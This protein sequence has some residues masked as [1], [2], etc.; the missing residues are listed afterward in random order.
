MFVDNI[1]AKQ[2][3]ER[4]M[5]LDFREK[6]TVKRTIK[7]FTLLVVFI[8]TISFIPGA[9]LS[10]N[11]NATTGAH[12]LKGYFIESYDGKAKFYDG[13]NYYGN[14]TTVELQDPDN[15]AINDCMGAYWN[16]QNDYGDFSWDADYNPGGWS[17]G[18][19]DLGNEIYFINEVPASEI[20]GNTSYVWS[21]I[22]EVNGDYVA[23]PR[24]SMIGQYEPIPKPELENN[25]TDWIKI[26]VES[27]DYTDWDEEKGVS[28]GNGTYEEFVSYSVFIKGGGYNGWTFVG[29]TNHVSESDYDGQYDDPIKPWNESIDPKT[30]TT[31]FNT[32]NAT[33]L[34]PGKQYEFKVR[35]NIGDGLF[36]GYN[37]G[38]D[39]AYT[40]WGSGD[41]MNINT[42][43][44]H[45]LNLNA[46]NGG[47][48]QPSP[49]THIYTK[50]TEVTIEA[51]PDQGYFFERW[52]GDY[53]TGCQKEKS[54]NVIMDENKSLTAD[55]TEKAF[56]NV[57]I[58]GYDKEI[59]EG[60]DIQINYTVK[61]TGGVEDTQDIK[62]EVYSKE[63]GNPITGSFKTDPDVTIGPD[64]TQSGI[65]NW[66]TGDSSAGDYYFKIWSGNDTEN[67]NFA[68]LDK[69][70]LIVEAPT[71]KGNISVDG[72]YITSY[73][74]QQSFLEGELVDLE[75]FAD[76]GYNFDEWSGDNSTIGDNTSNKTTIEMFDNYTIQAQFD[77]NTYT[78]NISSKI[79]G[80]VTI[81]GRGQYQFNHGEIVDLECKAE[82][83]YHFV[84]WSGDNG[85]IMNTSDNSTSIEILD[86][87]SIT[88]EF[89]INT[90][91]LEIS[92]SSG[93]S[94]NRPGEGIFHYNHGKIIDLEAVSKK[95]YHF[96]E[97]SGDNAT[98]DDTSA[99]Q[100]TIKMLNDYSI[101]AVFNISSYTLNITSENGGAVNTPGEGSFDYEYGSIIELEALADYG[102]HFVRWSGDNISI[103]NITSNK[104]SIKILSDYSITAEFSINT[105]TL[106]ISSSSGGYVHLPGEGT[107][108][109]E[110]G[111]IV[112][113]EAVSSEGYHF[114]E[115]TGDNSTISNTKDNSTSIEMLDDHTITAMFN[116]NS[117]TLTIS[118]SQGGNVVKPGEGTH[119]YDHGSI[120]D[121]EGLANEGYHFVRWAGD[122]ETITDTTS[123]K[124]TIEMLD[125]YSINAGFSINTYTLNIS[126]TKG[127]D[128]TLP[129]EGTYQ[130]SHGTA[131][132]IE[133]IADQGRSF[134]EWTGDN[135]TVADT[136]SNLTTIE[137]LNDYTIIAEFN[138][139]TYELTI[140][141]TTGGTVIK[142]GETT[143]TFDHGKIVNIE[144]NADQGYNFVEWTGDN[145]T[146]ADTTDNST[147][148]DMLDNYTITAKFSVN[149]YSLEISSSTGG[150]VTLPGEGTHQYEH[151]T[152]VN[153]K[154]IPENGYHFVRW[155]GDNNSIKNTKDNS[156]TIE[157][158]DD[159]TITALFNVNSYTLT[160]SSTSGGNVVKP[161][162]GTHQYEHGTIVDLEAI[163]QKGYHFNLWGGDNGTITED[164]SNKT[165]IEMFDDYSIIAKFDI[166]TYTLDI[167]STE[168]GNVIEP[169][170][171][172]YQYEHGTTI[173]LEVVSS[174][175]YHFVRW[176][177]DN[178]SISDTVA[179]STTIEMLND[180]SIT[181]EFRINT[182]TLDISSTKGGNVAEPGEGT[183]QY[184]HGTS[185]DIE[186]I[187]DQGRSFVEWTG[188][189]NTVA[190]T[191]SNLTTIEML[192]DYTIIAEF[193]VRTYELTIDST[194]GGTVIQPEETTYSFNHGKTVNIEALAY[195]G[196]HFVEW[197]G[198]N[199]TIANTKRNQTTIE[200]LDD[201]SITAKFDINTYSLNIISS[202]NGSVVDPGEGEYRYEHGTKVDIEAVSDNGYH[203]N[204]WSG[205][206]QTIANKNSNK[207][208]IELLSECTITAEFGINTYTL[209]ISSSKGG[210]VTLPGEG[211]YNYEY[212][213]VVDLK[214]VAD[215]DYIFNRWTGDVSQ[216]ENTQKN[217]TTINIKNN[218]S[219]A[220]NFLKVPTFEIQGLD[221]SPVE[222]YYEYDTLTIEVDIHNHGDLEGNH[223]IKIEI[224]N[225]TIGNE[226]V[227]VPPRDDV[228]VEID[229]TPVKKDLGSK[230]ITVDDQHDHALS[231][232]VRIFEHPKVLTK[233]IDEDINS[234]NL[235]GNL[236]QIGLED[237]I[238]AYF[239]YREK[240]NSNWK[241]SQ[242][243]TISKENSYNIQV[244][245]L[246]SNT[247]YEYKAIIKWDSRK[248]TGKNEIFKT[249]KKPFF[250]VYITN[251]AE[252]DSCVEGETV[253]IN[254][255]VTNIGDS[256]DTQD[257]KFYVGDK[258]LDIKENVTI[259]GGKI[260]SDSFN[261]TAESPGGS[262]NIT[263]ETE[264]DLYQPK[265]TVLR[266]SF[267]EV[268]IN[269][270]TGGE[271]VESNNIDVNYTVTN[272][273]DVKDTQNIE[274]FV[275][276]K[277]IATEENVTIG[278][279][280]N[281]SGSFTWSVD[282]PYG[283][284]ELKIQTE[285]NYDDLVITALQDAFLSVEIKS[286]TEDMKFEE[287]ENVTVDYTVTNIGDISDTQDINLYVDDELVKI[288]KNVTLEG[289]NFY[290]DSFTWTTKSPGS[291]TLKV[292]TEDDSYEV[293]LT[294]KEAPPEPEPPYFDINIINF[295]DEIKEGET[296][297]VKYNV[298]NTGDKD[299]T[300]DLEFVVYEMDNEVKS[301]IISKENVLALDEN[302]LIHNDSEEIT[303]DGGE[304]YE[305]EF[306]WTANNP[307]TYKIIF[308][309]EEDEDNIDTPEPII[310][311][312]EE[313]GTSWWWL[314]LILLILLIAAILAV[315]LI[316]ENDFEIRIIDSKI[317]SDSETLSVEYEVSNP[318]KKEKTEDLSF[319][320]YNEGEIISEE[321]KEVTLD[322]KETSKKR[323]FYDSEGT[324]E[325][326]VKITGKS[327]GDEVIIDEEKSKKIKNSFEE[328]EEEKI[329]CP[330]CMAEVSSDA[331]ECPE[332]GE[333]LTD[334]EEEEYDEIFEDL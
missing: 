15:I 263:V 70:N 17:Q 326:K 272:I 267:F 126:S 51:T 163:A 220:A 72:N 200:I 193:N 54:I 120:V 85:T 291:L 71:G 185:V 196:F 25:G 266:N 325:R 95:G 269:K 273:G 31:G 91:S 169:G 22:R 307:G 279:G 161:G 129:G 165:T 47:T 271:F 116:I 93:G 313:K 59:V 149:T 228:K 247:T 202:D 73:P 203:F 175:G 29:N 65:F 308:D 334:I 301:M 154:G 147:T 323:F 241:K 159:Y 244:D 97:W 288:N 30:V 66:S 28:P 293:N 160:I 265:V 87:Y 34:K 81:P 286:P 92:S 258:L 46:E 251:T 261:W 221:V 314:L 10:N 74:Y 320:V 211:S 331:K 64:D 302:N 224:D 21:A 167:S 231:K 278:S 227:T 235:F 179:N 209:E 11:L 124:T 176:S 281:Y 150:N 316:R 213:S 140:D 143:Y 226:T 136:S 287:G 194:T 218:Y 324:G 198:D 78:L 33:G 24:W 50:G 190:D 134:V 303:L 280:E 111:D 234:A 222:L 55:F 37:G 304:N 306:S 86:D 246:K 312:V 146:I 184:N 259:E 166:N 4:Q 285:D 300:C 80:N 113:L 144:A 182:Y 118:S 236:T 177:G 13:N 212:G 282:E 101:D 130:Y 145:D 174:M 233:S 56:F 275:D 230:T 333:P 329:E 162:E 125:D 41:S 264:D 142:P 48:T 2:K 6:G 139:R 131:V 61:N 254:Y 77:I 327:D 248:S 318:V 39:N 270:P 232:N 155:I 35:M 119:Q 294:V 122:N 100:T 14:V 9:L 26:G 127:G 58:D 240:G 250:D 94:V 16:E 223:T 99:N 20:N 68:V 138:V 262:K 319:T 88:A 297:N 299:A 158:L 284:R 135:N 42:K 216:I 292:G 109:Y 189:N 133:A 148:I 156:T 199:L 32:F 67:R 115:W 57:T 12:E 137:M 170:E 121:I 3:D 245:D 225:K 268:E 197:I 330:L 106:D 214:A 7:L 8:L 52:I 229:Y 219:I 298:T 5:F 277:L 141:S 183:Y 19:P 310:V 208:Q 1:N 305:S 239:L 173:D 180:Y 117:Y 206:I 151:G 255:T 192:N 295:D 82:E 296:L 103:G 188:D 171:D 237:N 43:K 178:S 276:G 217:V 257:I 36:G 44:E 205:D 108:H 98:I 168:G 186:A 289:N 321:S 152:L 207:T 238:T 53:P 253:N 181:A 110:H 18:A 210:N 201:Y 27:P 104:T 204:R 249:L 96:I 107:H 90:Y 75:A 132:D 38:Y 195:Q 123:N 23:D 309:S 49:G 274:Y 69:Y 62:F 328:V 157:M 89:E 191:S 283:D 317:E 187:A 164:R 84:E 256:S 252:F 243:R 260:H 290:L 215:H 79:G 45:L 63:T 311:E 128:V 60:E 76:S 83:G 153:L 332:C 322:G 114:F 172:V 315:L 102:Y 105:Y 40:T 112:N 242:N